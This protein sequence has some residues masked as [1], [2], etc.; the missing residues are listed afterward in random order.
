MKKLQFLLPVLCVTYF[1]LSCKNA[2]KHHSSQFIIDS[3]GKTIPVVIN[4]EDKKYQYSLRPAAG[5]NYNYSIITETQTKIEVND[6]KIETGN[7]LEIG[8][9]YKLVKD[10]SGN[11][12]I[13]IS[14]SKIHIV[15]QKND[16]EDQVI[17][18]DVPDGEQTTVEKLLSTIKGSS[19]SIILNQNGDII[20][21]NGSKEISD[22]IM[23]GIAT[24][25]PKMKQLVQQLLLKL[26][27]D[28]FIQDNVKEGF[29]L[30]PD[31]A[32]YIGDSWR[33]KAT[34]SAEISFE[35]ASKYTLAS[36]EDDIATI[37][38]EGRISSGKNAVS[39]IMGQQVNTNLNGEQTGRFKTDITTGM[40][41]YG[42]TNTT[43]NGTINV[44]GHEVPVRI[45]MKKEVILK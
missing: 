7:K 33:R 23:A 10:S 26:T 12:V 17:D 13:K 34:Q 15:I 25:E 1:L 38:V 11:R 3:T 22:K 14:Y 5:K 36:V 18:S 32:V 35:T 16:E 20:S 42:K 44:Q 40:L 27:G 21:S 31:T 37:E 41:Q 24:E 39:N 4:E 8:L 28:G 30:F 6:K 29:K 45:K 2:P 19:V 9:V 43:I